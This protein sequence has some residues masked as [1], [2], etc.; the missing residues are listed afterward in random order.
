[1]TD[2]SVFL[3]INGLAGRVRVIDEFF[4]GV[5]ND[6]FPLITACLILVWLWFSTRD[7]FQREQNQKA[8]IAC[9]GAIGLASG[10]VALCNNY[11]FR[12]RPFE[13]LS[14]DTIHLLFYRPTD[15]SFPSNLAAVIFAI[16]IPVF[17]K[18][19]SYG[20]FLLLLAVVSSFGRIYI[21]IHYPLDVIAGAGLGIFS[22]FL[23]MAIL[24]VLKPFVGY[25]LGFLQKYHLA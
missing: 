1:V 14:S 23:A 3:F 10:F 8:V 25:L 21:G 5:S 9:I 18:N 7:S 2:T 20:T 22:A 19:R 24:W 6:Y 4:K 16:A 15:S 17:I 11:Y 13:V 12:A